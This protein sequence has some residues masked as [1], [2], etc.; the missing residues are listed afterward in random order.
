MR[1][2]VGLQVA[3]VL[4]LTAG[5]AAACGQAAA[6]ATASPSAGGVA[7]SAQPSSSSSGGAGGGPTAAATIAAAPSGGPPALLANRCDML[8]VATIDSVT[9]LSVAAGRETEANSSSSG[10]CLWNEPSVPIGVQITAFPEKG[11]AALFANAAVPS[12]SGL[13]FPAKGSTVKVGPE[14]GASLYVDF[15]TFGMLIVTTSPTATL[16]MSVA[17]AN[18]LR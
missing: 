12:V 8:D 14:T 18:A 4:L 17:L 3:V 7:V 6:T 16:A 5:L 1:R 10:G 13:A 11:F 15:G 2:W 9:G